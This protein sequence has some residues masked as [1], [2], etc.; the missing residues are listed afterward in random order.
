MLLYKR[1]NKMKPENWET[2]TE[3]EKLAEVEELWSR[4]RARFVLMRALRAGVAATAGKPERNHIRLDTVI[5]EGVA[6]MRAE[7]HAAESDTQDAEA[8]LEVALGIG[9]NVDLPDLP[10]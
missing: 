10:N 4:G 2:M 8:I 9:L 6:A 5:R 1:T 3:K 7:T